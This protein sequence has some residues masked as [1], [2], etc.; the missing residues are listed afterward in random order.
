MA[1]PSR[2]L[3]IAYHGHTGSFSVADWRSQSL[4]PSPIIATDKAFSSNRFAWTLQVRKLDPWVEGTIT[5][6]Y[7]LRKK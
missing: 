5:D 6:F 1:P 7:V 3:L 2:V 4:A